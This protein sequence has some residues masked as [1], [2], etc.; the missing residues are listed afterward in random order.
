MARFHLKGGRQIPYTAAEEAARDAEEMLEAE[1]IG[2]RAAV[3]AEKE[4]RRDVVRKQDDSRPVTW[5]ELKP[6]LIDLGYLEP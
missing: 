3:L 4:A 5:G 1:K 2:Q 6:I